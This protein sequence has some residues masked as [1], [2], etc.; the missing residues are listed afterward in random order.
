M[1]TERLA[2][3]VSIGL[4]KLHTDW[5]ETM[6]RGSESLHDRIDEKSVALGAQAQVGG[7]R[8]MTAWHEEFDDLDVMAEYV[9]LGGQGA[10]RYKLVFVIGPEHSAAYFADRLRSMLS[11]SSPN[12]RERATPNGSARRTGS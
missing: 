11:A 8:P 7:G 4:L 5:I 10:S 1:V 2:D 3:Q 12:S 6:G 9:R